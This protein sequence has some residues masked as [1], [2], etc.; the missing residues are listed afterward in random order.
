MSG[1]WVS[2]LGSRVSG[3]GAMVWDSGLRSRRLRGLLAREAGHAAQRRHRLVGEAERV[4]RGTVPVGV[5]PHEALS[6]RQ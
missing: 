1:V 5:K 3:F 4:P 2:G 6:S